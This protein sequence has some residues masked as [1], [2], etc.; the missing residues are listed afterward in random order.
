M[1]RSPNIGQQENKKGRN[2]IR[3]VSKDKG[4]I[5]GDINHGHIK[6]K[7]LES[8]VNDVHQFQSCVSF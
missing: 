6:W 3:E 1:H 2:A 5:M 8:A 4:V 7:S